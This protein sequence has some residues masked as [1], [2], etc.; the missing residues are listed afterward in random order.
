[1]KC[2]C[3]GTEMKKERELEKSILMRC[4]SCGISDTSLKS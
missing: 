2:P 3:C 1:M 4:P